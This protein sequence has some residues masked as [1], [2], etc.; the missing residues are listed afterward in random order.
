M[1]KRRQKRVL[2]IDVTTAGAIHT[3]SVE[4]D[5]TVVRILGYNFTADRLDLA[6]NRGTQRLEINREE[7]YADNYETK[8]LIALGSVPPNLRYYRI[9]GGL[10]PGNHIVKVEYKD[11][12]HAQYPFTAYRVSLNLD[13]EIN[14]LI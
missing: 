1:L 8:H 11:N 10:E 2:D 6:Y 3:K 5:K 14:E 13:L 4:L 7:I 12:A 9:K